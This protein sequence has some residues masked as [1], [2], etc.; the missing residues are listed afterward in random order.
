LDG[1]VTAG[2][3]RPRSYPFKEIHP[4]P[5]ILNAETTSV[6]ENLC[7]QVSS[8]FL[9][10]QGRTKVLG[11]DP[12]RHKRVLGDAVSKAIIQVVEKHRDGSHDAENPGYHYYEFL[13]D[14]SEDPWIKGAHRVPLHTYYNQTSNFCVMLAL[15][16]AGTDTT[17]LRRFGVFKLHD[18]RKNLVLFLGS[19]PEE[20]LTIY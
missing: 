11:W 7:G 18:S 14:S 8:G 6:D 12:E 19:L 15:L 3:P 4:R 20:L 13:I 16:L 1:E 17:N 9:K 5:K 2:D 10:I